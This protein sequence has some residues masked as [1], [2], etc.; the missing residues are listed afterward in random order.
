MSINRKGSYPSDKFFKKGEKLTNIGKTVKA[1]E[2]FKKSIK[3]NPEYYNG[4][5]V[6]GSLYAGIGNFQE[7]IGWFEKAIKRFPEAADLWYNKSLS[8]KKLSRFDEAKQAV[9]KC[10]VLN[11]E[12]FA[13]L[14]IKGLLCINDGDT[15]NALNYFDKAL[16]INPGYD[17]AWKNKISILK[18]LGDK[19][20]L[21]RFRAKIL[22]EKYGMLPATIPKWE[23]QGVYFIKLGE[24]I[25]LTTDVTYERMQF[26]KALYELSSDNICI[27]S[28]PEFK[29]LLAIE[30]KQG[31]INLFMKKFNVKAVGLSK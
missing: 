21:E 2:E 3:K 18:K 23:H 1:I 8:L 7:S 27:I 25:E 4:Y 26:V 15:E 6:I 14:T 24:I 13:A 12:H 20:E 19:K 16:E 10:L 31:A 28:S 9:N 30:Q 17:I 22:K 29:P 11:S 5:A